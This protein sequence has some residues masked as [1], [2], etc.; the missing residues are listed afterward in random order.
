MKVRVLS[1]PAILAVVA[2]MCV[3]VAVR[4]W[5]GL[6][7]LLVVVVIFMIFIYRRKSDYVKSMKKLEQE[8]TDLIRNMSHEIR[9]P[10]NA[11]VGFSQLLADSGDMF[12]EEER[13]QFAEN[14]TVN[15]NLLTMM[16]NDILSMAEME[17][18]DGETEPV[19]TDCAMITGHSLKA[20][21]ATLKKDIRLYET[22]SLPEGFKMVTDPLRVQQILMNLMNNACKYT[23][24]GEIN[25]NSSYD[26]KSGVVTFS[27]T[28]T[29]CGIP[30]DRADDIFDRFVKLDNEKQGLGMGLA[31]CREIALRLGGNVR[32]DTSYIGGSRFCLDLPL[33]YR[34]I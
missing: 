6:V 23:D 3:L 15:T 13:R 20:V 26:P 1:V 25:L 33:E 8:K 11:I 19:E 5:S 32:L 14:I 9:T 2:I 24:Q 27:V 10:L 29:G 18:G 7:A 21:Q 22:S 4:A 30:S 31:L 16:L 34:P 12:S 28:D 17:N